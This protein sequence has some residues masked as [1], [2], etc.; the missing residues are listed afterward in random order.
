ME[1]R[2][3]CLAVD[4]G[5]VE[6]GRAWELQKRLHAARVRQEIGDML[7]L[8]EHPPTLT[9]G[10]SGSMKNVLASR[11][12]LAQLGISLF[13]IERGGDVT[14]HGP[15]QIVGYPI[16]DLKGRDKD[17][18]RFVT[19]LEEVMIRTARDFHVE[20][21]RDPE[22]RGVWV[23]GSEL[24]AIGLS[25]R[26]W[27]SMHGFAFNVMTNLDHFTIINPCGFSDRQ[28]TSLAALLGRDIST[29]TA[30]ERVQ[31][32]FSAVFDVDIIP[33]SKEELDRM[34]DDGPATVE[35]ALP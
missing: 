24:G 2:P 29:G 10:K 15:G 26:R 4:L 6:Y 23:G 5:T 16:M 7:L 35:R 32:H 12:R 9:M 31:Y 1:G 21:T 14:Y 20:A 30:K 8:L 3:P 34:L 11:E 13:L 33:T 27:V 25:I 19:D 17:I 28:A 18:Y 22:H